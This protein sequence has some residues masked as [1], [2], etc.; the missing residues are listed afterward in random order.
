[1]QVQRPDERQDPVEVRLVDRLSENDHLLGRIDDDEA[2]ERAPG[3]FGERCL[4]PELGGLL[5][6]GPPS[7]AVPDVGTVLP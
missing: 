1:M 2:V 5:V 3:T 4:Y 7:L 6:I